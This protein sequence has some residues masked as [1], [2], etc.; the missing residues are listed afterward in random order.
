MF[1]SGSSQPKTKILIH[2]HMRHLYGFLNHLLSV[3]PAG[4]TSER[5]KVA[6]LTLSLT[7]TLVFAAPVLT[8]SNPTGNISY[9]VPSPSNPDIMAYTRQDDNQRYLHIYHIATG[10]DERV[11]RV[12]RTEQNPGNPTNPI[13]SSTRTETEEMMR[14]AGLPS[15]H[16][17][18][19]FSWWPVLDQFGYKW[20]T[21]TGTKSGKTQLHIGYI[22]SN[23]TL[24]M[25]VFP[26]AFGNVV[27]NPV[28]SPDGNALVFSA[29]GDLY[30]VPDIGKVIRMRD[31]SEMNPVRITDNPNGC[32]F[33]AWSHDSRMIAYQSSP[34][35]G[36]RE[37]RE[38]IYVIDVQTVRPG[39]LPRS[40][41]VSV[42]DTGNAGASHLRPSWAPSTRTLAFYEHFDANAGQDTDPDVGGEI[43][44]NEPDLDHPSGGEPFTEMNIR[45]LHLE[46][47][48]NQNRWRGQPLPGTAQAYIAEM[49]RA[50]PRSG[51]QWATIDFDRREVTGI[52]W[53]KHDPDLDHPL[54]FSNLIRYSEGR[55]DFTMN[56]FSF[57]NRFDWLDPTGNNRYPAVARADRQTRYVYVARLDDED[58]LK[59]ADR[60]STT[61]EP[62]VRK[63]IQDVPATIRSGLYPGWG[64]FHIGENR[65]GAYMAGTFTVLA[66]ATVFSSVHRYQT[67][68]KRPGN[69]FLLSLGTATAAFWVFN[70]YDLQRHLPAYR[71]LPVSAT[72]EA[73]MGESRTPDQVSREDV[74]RSASKT[75]AMT[76][77]ALYPG[78]GHLYIHQK[79]KAFVLT[80]VF[81]TL[82]GSTFAGAAYR[83][84]YPG[85]T[86]SNE[87][88][89]AMGAATLGIWIYSLID[90]HQSFTYAFFADAGHSEAPGVTH[91]SLRQPY[92]A[93]GPKVEYLQIGNRPYRE[94]AAFGF[95]LSF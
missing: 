45:L 20:F 83:Y 30:L 6:M 51:P 34:V 27:T 85:P 19:D 77:S 84:N 62:V 32:Y 7:L 90:L 86:P 53:V 78:L 18:G 26:I 24:N 71:T 59:V 91:A 74:I 28:F 55:S 69:T 72:F 39:L 42:I 41:L 50:F 48:R 75:R 31:F 57:S 56:L 92:V 25:A 67:T 8:V 82:A 47:D 64:H 88:L 11:T 80:G 9:P 76:L 14:K 4:H 46:Y 17:E 66:G 94:Y 49:A 81:T 36:D 22:T 93:M 73:Y 13:R 10:I 44:E 2:T 54:Y 68:G 15:G 40:H 5:R 16:F 3:L 23:A 43:T 95:S 65:R 21:F 29:D 79:P 70:I 52:L 58:Q 38:S 37:D 33:P 87:V 63:E 89:I 12:T 35:E 61:S 60:R 1:A